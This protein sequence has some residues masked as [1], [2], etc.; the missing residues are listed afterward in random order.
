MA[1]ENKQEKTY[2]DMKQFICDKVNWEH[3]DFALVAQ[4]FW[5]GGLGNRSRKTY[6]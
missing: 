4:F 2:I 3:S 6:I 5:T 1:K